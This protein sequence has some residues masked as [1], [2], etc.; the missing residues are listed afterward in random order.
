MIIPEP[1]RIKMIEPIRLNSIHDRE[2]LIRKA[3]YNLFQLPADAVFIDLLTDSGTG[4]MSSNQWAAIM[5][6]DESYAGA[7]SFYHLQSTVEDLF[8]FPYLLPTHQ[9]R[10]AEHVFFSTFVHRGEIVPSN[11]HFDT[12]RANLEWFE[13]NPVDLPADCANDPAR[14]CSF[15]G[16]M[17]TNMLIEVLE[18]HREKVPFVMLTVTN[19]RAAGSPVSRGNVKK[20]SEICHEYGKP[21]II[22][23]CRHAENAFF[24]QQRDPEYAKSAIEWITSKFFSFADGLLMSAQKDGLCN[25]GGFIAVKNHITFERLK[26]AL[27]LMEGFNTYGGLAGRDLNAMSIGLREAVQQDYLAHRIAQVQFLAD[28]LE[29]REIP[30]YKPVGGHAVFVDVK[31]FFDSNRLAF[32]GQSLAVALYLEGG[33]RSCDIGSGMFSNT[34]ETLPGAGL[35]LE[36]LRLAIPR[37]TYTESHLRYV[38]DIFAELNLLKEEIPSLR[39]THMPEFLGHFQAKFE[40]QV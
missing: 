2:R 12:T 13:A 33:I 7:S 26:S 3:N 37:R 18:K 36:L 24:I 8:G 21:L 38:A 15:K 4:S 9:G 17:N 11:A 1:Y 40:L 32:P 6:G 28:E 29:K 27:I 30:V 39:C 31:R 5:Q 20:V 10:A 34:E 14:D 16:N 22:D 35:H 25:I 23:A 19:N